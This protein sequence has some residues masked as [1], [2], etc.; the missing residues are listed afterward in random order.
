MLTRSQPRL[1][2]ANLRQIQRLECAAERS[3]MNASGSINP[4]I[5]RFAFRLVC[6]CI[7]IC[8]ANMFKILKSARV[9]TPVCSQP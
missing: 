1:T 4:A 3:N 9:S 7:G 5:D 8:T 2:A 6:L